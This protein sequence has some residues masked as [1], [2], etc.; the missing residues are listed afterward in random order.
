MALGRPIAPS[1]LVTQRAGG[2]YHNPTTGIGEPPGY[3]VKGSNGLYLKGYGSKF[4]GSTYQKY[5]HKGLDLTGSLEAAVQAIEAGTVVKVNATIGQ[6]VVRFQG[7][8]E[9]F[10]GAVHCNSI[11][12][13]VGAKVAK[14]QRIGGMG[15]KGNASGIHDHLTIEVIEKGSDG[16]K[17]RLFYDPVRFYPPR[18]FRYK[19]AYRAAAIAAGLADADGYLPG[20]DLMYA[21]AIYPIRAVT[22]NDGVYVRSK[23]D[24][25]APPLTL[26]TSVTP[27]TQ[28]NEIPGGD[29][30]LGG[31]TANLWAK[32]RLPIAGVVTTG[33]VA[34]PLIKVV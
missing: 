20:G 17:R 6:I 16:V 10:Y 9:S 18:T 32:V 3:F 22:V 29:Y 2:S 13:A 14:G 30:T 23:P 4:P 8:T 27:A 34:K 19:L 21:D 33:Y 24:K 11:A 31:V 15:K 25:A 28:V 5:L 12:V 1:L 26:T 7:H